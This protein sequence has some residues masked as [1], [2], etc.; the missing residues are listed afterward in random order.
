[1]VCVPKTQTALIEQV[2]AAIKEA[3]EGALHCFDGKMPA[4]IR[5]TWQD[6]Q[7]KFDEDPDMHNML[8]DYFV[9]QANTSNRPPQ[10]FEGPFRAPVL[11]PDRFQSGDI[12]HVSVSFQAYPKGDGFKAGVKAW[13]NGAVWLSEAPEGKWFEST[14]GADCS[15]DFDGLDEDD[16]SF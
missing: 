12:C 3:A 10:L 9:F 16:M 8:K 14:G 13:L 4:K 6:G 15:S 11:D 7:E 1:M 2:Q 5:S